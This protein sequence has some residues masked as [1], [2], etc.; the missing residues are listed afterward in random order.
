MGRVLTVTTSSPE[1]TRILGA[2]LA[3]SLLPGDVISLTGDLGAGKTVFV[4][5]LASALGVETRVTS[6][7][8]T[9]VH[10]YQGQFPLVHMDVYRLDSFQEVI[11]LGFDE[12]I[13]PEAILVVEWGEAVAPLLPS[14]YLEIELRQPLDPEP[15]NIRHIFLRPHGAEWLRKLEAMR[16]AAE[17]LLDAASPGVSEGGR[18]LDSSALLARDHSDPPTEPDEED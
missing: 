5:G 13:D 3:P 2:S 18:F 16:R 6:P 8:F 4:Q 17:A 7:S 15:E 10:T 12:L 1:E 11:D 14:R 9:I